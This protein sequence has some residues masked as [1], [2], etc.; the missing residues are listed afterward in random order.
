MNSKWIVDLN[1]R[2]KTIKFL[3]EKKG[4]IFVLGLTV[5]RNDTKSEEREKVDKLYLTKMK[6][7]ALPKAVSRG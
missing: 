1:L 3:G 6:T 7:L 2:C 4:E 5:L